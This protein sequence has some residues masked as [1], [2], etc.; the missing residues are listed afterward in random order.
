[1]KWVCILTLS[2]T[3]LAAQ[4]AAPVKPKTPVTQSSKSKQTS[5]RGTTASRKVAYRRLP[6]GRLVRVSNKRAAPS[7]QVHPDA[8]RYQ[9]I[10]QSLADRGYFKG[11]VNGQWGDDSVDAMKRFQTD[12]KIPNDGKVSSLSLIGL[13]LGP[14]HDG[15]A[16]APPAKAAP[17]ETP[18]LPPAPTEAT[19]PP[20]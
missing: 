14:R 1:M 8:T 6:N 19:P 12:Q 16:A 9:E 20:Q 2:G 4:S 18:E 15:L 5:A 10:Q 7:Y 11:E 17:A 3:M 13:G